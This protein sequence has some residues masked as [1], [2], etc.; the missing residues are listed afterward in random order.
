MFP[1]TLGRHS[2]LTASL[3]WATVGAKYMSTCQTET[4][5]S[6]A[7]MLVYSRERRGESPEDLRE[8]Q[9]PLTQ[10]C[11]KNSPPP[12]LHSPSDFLSSFETRGKKTTPQSAF[13]AMQQVMVKVKRRR[14]ASRLLPLERVE[15]LH[16]QKHLGS[17][18]SF[19]RNQFI[20]RRVGKK[21]AT[22]N[23]PSGITVCVDAH[24]HQ[25]RVR[26]YSVSKCD[27]VS[28][29]AEGPRGNTRHD[30]AAY[31]LRRWKPSLIITVHCGTTRSPCC[32]NSEGFCLFERITSQK[33]IN[34][35]GNVTDEESCLQNKSGERQRVGPSTFCNGNRAIG[36]WT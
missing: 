34:I 14:R 28:R 24:P 23:K 4:S 5:I 36:L 25:T 22:A 8:K 21:K 33:L 32:G 9:A 17:A 30:E 35:R 12:T 10:P 18:H 29:V 19:L 20:N 31:L 16:H 7:V 2:A 3:L 13:E 27:N 15:H 11:H 1:C 6:S 26:N